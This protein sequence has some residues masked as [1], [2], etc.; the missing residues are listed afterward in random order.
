VRASLF[1]IP[2]PGPGT[3]STM[4]RPRGGDW[5]SD[6]MT[7]LREAG[8]DLLVSLLTDL[9][10]SELDLAAEPAAAE[11]AGLRFIT[12]PIQD[13]GVPSV[14]RYRDLVGRLGQ[15]LQAGSHVVVHCR[16]GIGRSSLV[17]VGVLVGEG[18]S[19]AEACRVVSA[20]RGMEVPETVEQRAWL[21][22]ILGEK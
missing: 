6:E 11:T 18:Q 4:P 7:A 10:A 19:V 5:L 21:E 9:E 2:R 14:A 16:G 12:F 20:A 3:I 13:M 15:E 8:A 17:A 22:A 1:T